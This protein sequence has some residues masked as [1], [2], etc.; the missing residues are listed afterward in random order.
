MNNIEKENSFFAENLL[1]LLW[2]SGVAQ[3]AWISRV[4][5]YTE[6]SPQRVAQLLAG[7]KPSAKEIARASRATDMPDT[8]LLY[9]RLAS[10]ADIFGENMNCLLNTLDHGG[11][12]RLARSVGVK[13]TAVTT[14]RK[15]TTPRAR[16]LE[17]VKEFFGLP[18][19]IDLRNCCLF[20][21]L[22]PIG[23]LQKREWVKEHI[24]VMNQQELND[25]FPALR[26]L[27]SDRSK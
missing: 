20:L 27:L 9:D 18:R 7:D 23:V 8:D 24:S 6:T 13:A 10:R 19:S 22:E 2:Q 14:W 17:Q 11:Q 16:T 25:L 4:G 21:S 26:R 5:Q 3:E 12:K 15:G 1:F